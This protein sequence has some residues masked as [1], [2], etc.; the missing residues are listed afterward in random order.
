MNGLNPK[1]IEEAVK[2]VRNRNSTKEL[3]H[4][5]KSY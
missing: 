4:E 1:D 5:K 3:K 2:K